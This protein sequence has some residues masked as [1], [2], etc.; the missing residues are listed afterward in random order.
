MVV[1]VVVLA[2]SSGGA[3]RASCRVVGLSSLADSSS[4]SLALTPRRCR[5]ASPRGTRAARHH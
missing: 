4:P 5:R 3:L 1:V 2:G